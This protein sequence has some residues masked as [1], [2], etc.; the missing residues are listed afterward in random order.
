SE[1]PAPATYGI[2]WTAPAR[3]DVAAKRSSPYR[4][5]ERI[6]AFPA[7]AERRAEHVPCT[8]FAAHVRSAGPHAPSSRRKMRDAQGHHLTGATSEALGPFDCAVRA[9]TRIYGDAAGLYDA[10]RKAA[11]AFVMAHLGKAWPF[12]LAN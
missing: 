1:P 11:P 6:I 7:G 5:R 2:A 10:A 12:V 8:L 3:R 4:C 9:F